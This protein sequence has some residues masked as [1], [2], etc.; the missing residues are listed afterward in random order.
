MGSTLLEYWT[1]TLGC[2]DLRK[3]SIYRM[4]FYARASLDSVAHLG[5]LPAPSHLACSGISLCLFFPL[6]V[7]SHSFCCTPCLQI[8]LKSKAQPFLFSPRA[9]S[10]DKP[11]SPSDSERFIAGCCRQEK[12]KWQVSDVGSCRFHT[13]TPFVLAVSGVYFITAFWGALGRQGSWFLVSFLKAGLRKP[14][15]GV[16]YPL[17]EGRL[18]SSPF[19]R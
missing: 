17:S 14:S 10:G 16:S 11:V 8:W 19:I 18:V 12:W 2:W 1:K 5:L 4:W 15:L 6:W 7:H 3:I 9:V 13:L